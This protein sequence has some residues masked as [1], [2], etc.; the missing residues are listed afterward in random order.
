MYRQYVKGK[1][2]KIVNNFEKKYNGGTL[3]KNCMQIIGL[4]SIP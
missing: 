2:F 4:Q 1:K 3:I